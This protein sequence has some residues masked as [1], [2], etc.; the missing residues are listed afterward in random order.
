[1]SLAPNA[2]VTL[3]GNRTL[4]APSGDTAGRRG[5]LR[6]VQDGSGGR[7]ITW[8]AAYKFEGGSDEKPGGTAA[9][10]TI[11]RYRVRGSGDVVVWKVWQSDLK[12]ISG[13]KEWDKSTLAADTLYT[14]AHG[15]GRMPVT[16]EVWLECT[17]N[18]NGITAGQRVKAGGA[19]GDGRGDR[20][21]SI[22]CDATNV[23]ASFNE[24]PLITRPDTHA[25]A[26]LTGS[27]WKVILKAFC[28]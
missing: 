17:T 1:M 13:W 9:A 15:F 6:V 14:Q 22:I 18:D 5:Y 21:V 7:S 20:V 28:E 24:L 4:N 11:Y 10:E 23:Y 12:R 3:G 16:A 19:T 26:T 8:N 27:S 2:V 25:T